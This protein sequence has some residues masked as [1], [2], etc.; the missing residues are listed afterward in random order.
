MRISK[1][2]YI[3]FQH[4]GFM[5]DMLENNSK[6]KSRSYCNDCHTKAEDGIY[7]DAIDIPGY[8]KWEAHRCMKF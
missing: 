4:D 8:G 6:I 5:A 1:I 7:A 3:R 2:P